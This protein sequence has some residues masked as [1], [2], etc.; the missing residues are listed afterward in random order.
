[1]AI[2]SIIHDLLAM[3]REAIIWAYIFSGIVYT[4]ISYMTAITSSGKLTIGQIVLPLLL[5]PIWPIMGLFASIYIICELFVKFKILKIW[6]QCLWR[7]RRVRDIEERESEMRRATIEYTSG[8]DALRVS[9]MDA[10]QNVQD[11]IEKEWAETGGRLT[12]YHQTGEESRTVY[13][14]HSL[15][16]RVYVD[17]FSTS[18]E[19]SQFVSG[20]NLRIYDQSRGQ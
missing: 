4:P 8:S 15:T 1:M 16:E 13:A 17:E 19:A 18:L 9:V 2:A 10:E 11:L 14:F 20:M 12:H 7:S 5:A 3:H 6:D